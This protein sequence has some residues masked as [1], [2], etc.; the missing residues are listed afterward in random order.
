MSFSLSRMF[1]R[2]SGTP[3]FAG[4]LVVTF[5][6][7]ADLAHE[8][9][10][11]ARAQRE[12]ANR[13]LRDFVRLSATSLAYRAQANVH[14]ALTPLFTDVG[15]QRGTS[16]SGSAPGPEAIADA[17][18]GLEACR[19][20][21]T[22]HARYYF[23]LDIANGEL[24]TTND[25][26]SGERL[27]LRDTVAALARAT[28]GV[29]SDV[30]LLYERASHSIVAFA[31]RRAPQDRSSGGKELAYAYGLVSDAGA[32]AD[33]VFAPAARAPGAASQP[34]ARPASYDS[35]ATA[36]VRATDG[37]AIYTTGPT[38]PAPRLTMVPRSGHETY[39][40]GTAS[41]RV[42][43][44]LADTVRLGD[45][46][47][48]LMLDVG[49]SG[50]AAGDLLDTALPPSR[51]LVLFG[52]LVLMAGLV[53]IA[54]MQLRRE[55]ELARLRA[56]FTTGVSHELRTPLAQ[57]LLYGETLMLERTRS[58]RERRAATEV[59][60]REARRLMHLVENALHFARADREILRLAP[61]PVALGPLTREILVA[62]APLAWAAN[63]TI[64][65]LIEDESAVVIDA[66][67]WRQI[68]LNLL[69]NAVKY[70]PA[71]QT[72]TVRLVRD[73]D[74]VCLSVDDEGPGVPVDDRERIW[75]PFVRLTSTRNGPM[76]TGIGLAV[77]RD[78][79]SRHG[80]RAWATSAQHG[81]RF[82]VE[83]PAAAPKES[84]QGDGRP[85]SRAAL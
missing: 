59:I 50:S 22:I 35:L 16:R 33:A 23:R 60:V 13:A 79:V 26:A 2:A 48:G 37:E 14:A 76:G 3:L 82:V 42:T 1:A 68:V 70:G 24:Q 28:H 39:V 41:P 66:A 7:A 78:L 69:D 38:R 47:G 56:D 81:G 49:V 25:A 53:T 27:W 30:I 9:W 5:A 36:T 17:A 65:D 4:L 40:V 51:L 20:A 46:F 45:Q 58:E 85:P 12:T 73:T 54:V 44:L 67:A 80:G 34:G 63:V 8:A 15:A 55:Q 64:R 77:V 18:A 52:L 72:I 83:L 57:I 43:P 6:I 21:P 71:G 19:C 10:M 74:H 32:F 84:D 61:E 29:G 75:A 11:T 31:W 62:F